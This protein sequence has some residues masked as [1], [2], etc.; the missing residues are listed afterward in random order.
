[1]INNGIIWYTIKIKNGRKYRVISLKEYYESVFSDKI[2]HYF[3][4][5]DTV[6]EKKLFHHNR[7]TCFINCTKL[8]INKQKY[9]RVYIRFLQQVTSHNTGEESELQK[10]PCCKNL[11]IGDM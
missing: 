2:M 9:D 1:M 3:P 5:I 7:W 8:R 4:H 11:L 6:L 10:R